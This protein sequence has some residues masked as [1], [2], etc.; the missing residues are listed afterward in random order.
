MEY[1]VFLSYLAK[2]I[3]FANDL[4]LFLEKEGIHCCFIRKDEVS[5]VD[6]ESE[7][8]C[9]IKESRLMVLLC[10]SYPSFNLSIFKEIALA[11][12][13]NK[14]II[15]FLVNRVNID[16]YLY[17]I[18]YLSLSDC[19]LTTSQT[20]ILVK[21][22][23]RITHA[24]EPKV[25]PWQNIEERYLIGAIHTGKVEGISNS[26]VYV[27]LERGVPGKI[28]LN[29]LSWNKKGV[30]P[31]VYFQ[32]G[33]L[34]QVMVLNIDKSKK[35]LV[36][37]YKQLTKNPWDTLDD[38]LKV[39]NHVR[40]KVTMIVDYGVFV[41]IPPGV[42]GLIQTKV[43]NWNTRQNIENYMQIGDEIDTV[44]LSLD[45]KKQKILLGIKLKDDLW[46]NIELKYP[47]GSKHTAKVCDFTNYGIF[48]ELEDGVNGM[49]HIS[50]LSWTKKINHPSDF[51]QKG[52]SIDVVILNIDKEK[53]RLE[54]G[55]KQLKDNPWD[56]YESIYTLGSIHFGKIIEV[57]KKGAVVALNEG[58]QGFSTSK[59]LIKEDGTSAQIGDELPFLIV[60]FIK[61]NK[62]IILSHKRTYEESSSVKKS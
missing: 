10:S 9:K 53:Q 62:R 54:L 14:K 39:G 12:Q 24:L 26:G 15:P 34:I 56:T 22:I 57:V 17:N 58:G 40:G 50:N 55:H 30:N 42:V 60:D 43:M 41:E 44:I 47:I 16:W 49:I 11:H 7:A 48:V 5:Q 52:S 27:R 21:T 32:K 59:H 31:F 8:V 4:F 25:D 1:D 33:D 6:Y 35:R 37:G 29:N 23:R 18:R 46:E 3:D 28:N 20:D 38:N 19:K 45:I 13:E 2:D 36:L 61:E 51:T